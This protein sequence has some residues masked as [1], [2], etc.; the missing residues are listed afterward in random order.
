MKNESQATAKYDAVNAMMRYEGG[1]EPLNEDEVVELFQHL[2][3]TGLAWSLQGHYGR[4]AQ[5]MIERGMVTPKGG[6]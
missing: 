5:A 3:D 1:G 4:T 2:V 6:E